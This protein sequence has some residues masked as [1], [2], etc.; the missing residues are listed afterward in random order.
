MSPERE[1]LLLEYHAH[2]VSIGMSVRCINECVDAL[3]TG[4]SAL[5]NSRGPR[6][7]V[8]IERAELVIE[9]LRALESALN[10]RNK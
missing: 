6:S 4:L 3:T 5:R 9:K 1:K 10:E 7:E 2:S 8:M